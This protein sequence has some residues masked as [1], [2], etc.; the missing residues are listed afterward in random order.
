M[1]RMDRDS[2]YKERPWDGVNSLAV[3]QAE[4]SANAAQ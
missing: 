4:Q 1:L 2:L 3:Y